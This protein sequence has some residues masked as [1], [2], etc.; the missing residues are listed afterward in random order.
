MGKY[1]EAI[2][3]TI[4]PL[5]II[6]FL[7]LLGG[8]ILIVIVIL[9]VKEKLFSKRAFIWAGVIIA[10]CYCYPIYEGVSLYLDIKNEDYITYHGKFEYRNVFGYSNEVKLIDK[11]NMFL[12]DWHYDLSENEECYYGTIVYTKRTKFVLSI[13]LNGS[14]NGQ[15]SEDNKDILDVSDMFYLQLIRASDF[16]NGLKQIQAV[17]FA[18][19][20]D[21]GSRL[22]L[23]SCSNR[24]VGGANDY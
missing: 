21:Y 8:L 14:Y 16:D 22:I 17:T 4:R 23:I 13:Q 1:S 19:K 2:R 12:S 20:F 5:S 6:D 10:I 7:F 9:G 11:N 15:A 3:S 18:D 24:C